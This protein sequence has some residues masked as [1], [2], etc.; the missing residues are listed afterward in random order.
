MSDINVKFIV[1]EGIEAQTNG[2]QQRQLIVNP[3][4]IFATKYIP[5]SLSLAVTMFATGVEAG[6]RT[7]NLIINNCT[8]DEDVFN[9]GPSEVEVNEGLDNFVV[10]ADLKNVAFETEGQ[11]KVILKI[12][13]KEFH[14]VFSVKK[15]KEK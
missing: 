2:F 14:D 5:T 15:T 3:V 7:I 9:S 10:S 6:K 11:Y 4:L 13:D 8:Q 12:D 1:S